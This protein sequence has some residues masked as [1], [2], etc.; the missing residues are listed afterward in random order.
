MAGKSLVELELR[1][2]HGVTVLAVRRDSQTS[3]NPEVEMPFFA[4]DILY[5]MGT[6]EKLTEST[7]LF[8][9]E[10]DFK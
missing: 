10:G 2:K 7:K 1:K 6:P 5:V 4:D 3:Y 9:C 8:S